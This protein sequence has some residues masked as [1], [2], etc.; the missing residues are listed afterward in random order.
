MTATLSIGAD[1]YDISVSTRNPVVYMSVAGPLRRIEVAGQ[2]GWTFL[3]SFNTQDI[4]WQ[5]DESTF[6]YLKINDGTDAAGALALA[7][8]ITFVDWDSWIARY[9]PEFA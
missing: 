6:A 9:A 1:N 8:N 7:N 4:A 5:V 2:P 3:S